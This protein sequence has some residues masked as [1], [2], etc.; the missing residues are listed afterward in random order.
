MTIQQQ[1]R[2][3]FQAVKSSGSLIR[4]RFVAYHPR[5]ACRLCGRLAATLAVLLFTSCAGMTPERIDAIIAIAGAAAQIGTQVWLAQHPTHRESFQHVIDA[6]AAE[7]KNSG[8]T[9]EV[10]IVALLSSLPTDALV[11]PNKGELYVTVPHLVV[12]DAKKQKATRVEGKA[13]A[14]VIKA[15]LMGLRRGVAPRPPIPPPLKFS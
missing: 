2:S 9:N 11:A 7:I 14:P 4:S 13:V 1:H 5:K 6:I 10:K 15:T 3:F 8:A 12:W